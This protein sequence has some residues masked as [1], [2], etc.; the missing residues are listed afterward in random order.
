VTN[1]A[2]RRPEVNY[3]SGDKH[4]RGADLSGGL[5]FSRAYSLAANQAHRLEAVLAPSPPP[6]RRRRHNEPREWICILCAPAWPPSG[7]ECLSVVIS[8]TPCRP[9]RASQPA[10]PSVDKRA[11]RERRAAASQR[12][13]HNGV[14]KEPSGPTIIIVSVSACKVRAA[15]A[16]AAAAAAAATTDND[17]NMYNVFHPP[18][19]AGGANQVGARHA[20]RRSRAN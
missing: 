10:G 1:G 13:T 20:S 8:L 2:R 7:R 3:K 16:A 9:A 4:G 18:L 12:Q 6:R 19:R 15:P 11:D 5:S 14:L 17:D